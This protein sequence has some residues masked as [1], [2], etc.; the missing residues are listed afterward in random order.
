MSCQQTTKGLTYPPTEASIPLESPF[1]LQHFADEQIPQLGQHKLDEAG[2]PSTETAVCRPCRFSSTKA[3]CVRRREPER[4]R[5]TCATARRGRGVRASACRSSEPRDA[6][7]TVYR[8]SHSQH[9]H[10]AGGII[11]VLAPESTAARSPH[12]MPLT[13][14]WGGPPQPRRRH[15]ASRRPASPSAVALR[16][17]LP[18]LLC[19]CSPPPDPPFRFLASLRV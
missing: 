17:Q 1:T 12:N 4:A 2:H 10:Q 3:P 16:P 11:S 8:E 18:H 13:P 6:R 9:H 5:E 7:C 15:R 14:C 19:I